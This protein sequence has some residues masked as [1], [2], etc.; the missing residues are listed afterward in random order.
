ML[1]EKWDQA[2]RLFLA[3]ADLAP[4][5]Q[6]LFLNQCCAD[7]LELRAEV[8]SLIQSDT[9][10]AECI[11]AAVESEA[12]RLFDSQCRDDRLGPYRV[13]R[14]L[15]RGGMGAVFLAT[16]DDQQYHKQVAIK[17]VKRGMDTAEVLER[18][19]HERQILANLDH[20]FIA[21]LYDG[22]S[23]A[24]GLPFFVMEYVEGQPIDVFCEQRELDTKTRLR[25]FLK[26]CEAVA[27]AHRNLVVHRDLKPANIFVTPT[28]T[29]KLLDFGIAKLVSPEPSKIATAVQAFTPDYASPEQVRGEAISTATD[30]YSLGAVLYELLT[31]ERAQ[32]SKAVTPLEVDRAICQTEITRPSQMAPHLDSDLDN[33]VLMAMSKEPSRRYASADQFAADIQRYLN[34]EP[35][36]AR[37]NSF[38]YR[39]RKFARRH[40]FGVA[41][42]ALILST[43][44]AALVVTVSEERMAQSARQAAEAQRTVAEG[45]RIRAER[46]FRQ[47]EA[48]RVAEL[49]QRLN[50]DQQRDQAV[51]E[52]ARAEQRLTQLLGLA[53][54]ALFQIHDVVARLPGA[55]EARKVLV[56]TTLDYLESIEKEHGLDDRL[57]L[58]L[59]GGYSRIAAIQGDTAGGGLGGYEGMRAGYHK[60]EVL[61]TP[62][63]ARK[64]N[65]PEVITRWLEV[66][67]GLADLLARHF[68]DK[69]GIEIYLRL[70]PV[71]HRLAELKPSD[72]QAVMQEAALERELGSVLQA[73]D[74]IAGLDHINKQIALME[75]LL[76]RFP[77]DRD[78]KEELASSLDAAAVLIKYSGDL[79]KSAEYFE[80]S[81]RIR[82]QFLE[83]EPHNA[84]VQR[85]LSAVYENYAALLG[86]PWSVNMGRFAEARSYC[87]KSVALARELAGADPQDKKARYALGVELGHLGMVQPDPDGIAESLATLME[88]LGILEPIDKA[89]PNSPSVTVQ[90]AL[91]REYAGYRLQSLGQPAAAREHF[92]MALAELEVVLS[93]NPGASSAIRGALHNE[94]GLAETY[95]T[96]GDRAAALTHANR[97]VDRAERYSASDPGKATPTA[98]LGESYVELASVERTFDQWDRAANAVD[99]ADSLWR[100]I[101]D[102]TVLLVHRRGRER[103]E[104][105]MREIAAH[106]AAQ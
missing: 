25:L 54:K 30:V 77:E 64:R 101:K 67:A 65:N 103:T 84:L 38:W 41:G 85:N 37:K 31:G 97:A 29:P 5:E 19:R 42:A 106:T 10:S 78:L 49:Q 22:G 83:A 7:D 75:S 17:V 12:S 88:A 51:R 95:V 20:P 13:L 71:A 91:V 46:G 43:L 86:L 39:T 44:V 55:A 56:R 98:Y 80:R 40:R 69:E 79:A 87:K 104:A 15:G 58:S 11:A 60:A 52:R 57:R 47:A 99:R 23:T 61:L 4:S 92:R 33:I 63:Y 27:Y 3:A 18:F 102:G 105:L 81:I 68:Q 16:R 90:I 59:A 32:K 34:G 50:A 9:G 8:E 1:R 72:R 14:Q 76:T 82:E 100:T 96:Q 93:S 36:V 26:V 35:V 6:A 89:N 24:D 48:A 66:E 45:E 28:E 94:E 62:L 73:T 70:I 21:R 53:D 2:Q 74:P